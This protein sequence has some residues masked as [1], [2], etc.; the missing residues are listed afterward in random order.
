VKI[1]LKKNNL[2][3]MKRNMEEKM[4][5]ITISDAGPSIF[6]SFP[7]FPPLPSPPLSS[8]L[9]PSPPLRSP[10]LPSPPFASPPPSSEGLLRRLRATC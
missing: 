10:L 7:I 2:K 9:L 6:L 1:L 4:I 5:A 3:I 8:S